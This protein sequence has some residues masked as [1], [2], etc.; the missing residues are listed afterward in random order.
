MDKNEVIK[1]L[2]DWNPWRKEIET[3]RDRYFYLN[4][5]ISFLNDNQ[6][7][8]I[9]GP[10]RA[11]KSFLLRQ[12][13]KNLIGENIS[14]NDILI[15]NFEDP[16]FTE[17][18]L[19][20]LDTV[21]E[22]YREFL[23]PIAKPYIFL[24]EVQEIEHW[25]KWV[26]MMHELNKARIVISGSNAKLLS[27][28]LATLLTG[29]HLDL[30]VFPLSFKEYLNFHQI[31][32]ENELDLISRRIEIKALF[33]SY[34]EFGSFPEVVLSQQKKDILLHY[35]ED[36]LNKDLIRRFKIRKQ[37]KLKSLAKFYLT[38]ISSLTTFS[39]IEKYLQMS[40][41]TIEKFSGYFEQA[42]FIFF[43]KRFSYKLKEQEKSP[44]KVYAMDTGLANVI[45]F[46][47]T[48]N[49]GRLAE[50]VVF[51]ELKRRQAA[52]PDLEI[53][54]WKDQYHREVDFVIKEQFKVRQ[55]IQVCWRFSE[56]KTKEREIKNL[57]KA[58]EEFKLKEGR[59]LTEDDEGEETI[60]G[61]KIIYQPLW[62]WLLEDVV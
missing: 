50:N 28:E 51:L 53:Y 58:M 62:K 19:K 21:Y 23:K 41:D 18:N 22:T 26:R 40:A 54:Y 34:L 43:L 35:F 24:D 52:N 3:G 48:Q 2:E 4:K 38:N 20:L 60:K 12:L 6:V 30:I 57:L 13:A 36:I 10:R 25:E 8:V 7:V 31:P 27:K 56:P 37:E 9:T 39:S 15:V 61:K 44:R 46:R 45:G 42:Y 16:G 29:R 47:F 5:P 14:K 55:L 49:Y 17:L 33:H 1:I 11:G 59:I 32:T